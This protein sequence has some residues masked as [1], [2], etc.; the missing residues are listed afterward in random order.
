M[1][2]IL[3]VGHALPPRIVTNEML[4]QL[5]DTSD[6]WIAQR[7]G[8]RARYWSR[9]PLGT[10]HG[11]G[12]AELGKAAAESA[13]QMAKIN[14]C[15][16]DAVVY[17]TISSDH[18]FPGNA[19]A[20]LT[21]CLGLRPV[22]LVEVRTHCSGFLSA[23]L[24]AD[25]FITCNLYRRVLVVACELQSSGLDVSTRGRA[26]A[27][28]FGDGAGAVVLGSKTDR[29]SA[30]SSGILSI[31]LESDGQYADKLG[32]RA[33]R[34]DRDTRILAEDY[35]GD[36]PAA[37]PHMDGKFVFRMASV[38]MPEIVSKVLGDAGLGI[39][40]F[41]LI[42]PHQANRRILDMVGHALGAS[43]RMYSNIEQ[44]GNTTA[45]SIPLALS[46]AVQQ[47]RVRSGDLVCLVS[48]GAGFAWGA[49]LVRW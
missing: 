18:E 4:A 34:F 8:I 48:F 20:V 37:F 27:V 15:E 32:V 7:S 35:S 22:P 5:M 1:S 21:D 44:H 13:L 30:E 47:G 49:A 16:L 19:G 36:A 2:D 39:D 17:A 46:Q 28:L 3:G 23:L 38:K 33:P 10:E 25:S 29:A 40:D 14:A 41:C 11:P 45:A 24:V 43:D 9:D 26:T 12:N 42:V 6:E 31:R